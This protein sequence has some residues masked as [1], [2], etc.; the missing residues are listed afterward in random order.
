MGVE[1][2]QRYKAS[3]FDETDHAKILDASNRAS[4]ERRQVVARFCTPKERY[5]APFGYPPQYDPTRELI[6]EVRPK[7]KERVEVLTHYIY[8]EQYIDEKRRY[9]LVQTHD[10]WPIDNR[11]ILSN[12]R[13]YSL[14]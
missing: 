12:G 4:E 2:Y 1:A 13:W 7:T 11:T 14:L 10:G 6:I 5:P 9:K 8:P 3:L